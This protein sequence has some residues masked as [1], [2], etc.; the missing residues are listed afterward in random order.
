MERFCSYQKFFKSF[1]EVG[2]LGDSVAVP[3][4]RMVGPSPNTSENNVIVH[5]MSA[6]DDN[7]DFTTV[8][9][10]RNGYP[11]FAA[12]LSSDG[13][14]Q[15]FRR[16]ARLRM[17][18]ILT[19]QDE[20]ALLENCLDKI[21][22]EEQR[23][24]FLGNL[25]RDSNEQRK[26]ILE[27]ISA[28][29]SK[30]GMWPIEQ[31]LGTRLISAL[32]ILDDLLEQS[33]RILRLGCPADRDAQSLR[34]WFN[35]NNSVARAETAYLSKSRDLMSLC[36]L[37]DDAPARLGNFVEDALVWIYQ[38]FRAVSPRR[39]RFSLLPCMSAWVALT[40]RADMYVTRTQR[41]M[42]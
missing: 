13:A 1:G 33:C 42:V 16:F 29:L 28:A 41:L 22:Q 6:R 36:A 19:K 12:L 32:G 34:N 35:G 39:R 27:R 31:T 15:V 25:R 20:L 4:L 5:L 17:R 30:Y 10:F 40:N 23:A 37:E 21:D 11:R 24:L 14:F 26:A 7:D 8:E 3:I 38:V 2:S 18:I 9:S